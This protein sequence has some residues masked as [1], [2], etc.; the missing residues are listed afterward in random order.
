MLHTYQVNYKG[1]SYFR[2]NFRCNM[3]TADWDP[4]SPFTIVNRDRHVAPLGLARDDDICSPVRPD[5]LQARWGL[6]A[7]KTPWRFL[8]ITTWVVRTR[9]VRTLQLET[10][11]QRRSLVRRVRSIDWCAQ[12]RCAPYRKKVG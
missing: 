9:E 8:A 10:F 4:G 11:G 6:C 7:K 1:I 3:S 5:A 12:K 2:V